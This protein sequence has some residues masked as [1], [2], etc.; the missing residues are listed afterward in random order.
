M[1]DEL[2]A[3]PKTEN[4]KLKARL[5]G[6][7]SAVQVLSEIGAA[8]AGRWIATRLWFI[9]LGLLQVDMKSF[10]FWLPKLKTMNYRK[11]ARNAAL[12][13]AGFGGLTII[14]QLV[15]P[16]GRILPGVEIQGFGVGGRDIVAAREFLEEE[17]SHA[18]LALEA[19]GQVIE[20]SFDKAG[21]RIDAQATA[22]AAANYPLYQRLIPFSSLFIMVKRDVVAQV[23]YDDPRLREFARQVS[24]RA[25]VPAKNAGVKIE[26]G[27]AKLVASEP[28]R[29]FS[30]EGVIESIKQAKLFPQTSIALTEV[31]NPPARTDDKVAGVLAAAQKVVD[32]PF[33]LILDGESFE[34]KKDDLGSWLDFAEEENGGLRLA[35]NRDA[36]QAYLEEVQKKVYTEPGTTVISLVD[37][38]E[39]G[40]TNA[41]PGRGIDMEVALERLAEAIAKAEDRVVELPLADLPPRVVYER[42][43]TSSSAGLVALLNDIAREKGDYGIAVMEIGGR[44]GMANADKQ[45]TAASTFKFFIAYAVFQ[46]VNSGKMSWSDHIVGGRNAAECFDAMIV[47]SDNACPVAFADKIGWQT[48][49]DM[50]RGLGLSSTQFKPGDHLTTANDLALFLHKLESGTL[51]NP[52]DKAR[53]IDA[54]KRQVYRR[55]IPA[56]VGAPVANKPGFLYDLLHDAGI[57]YGPKGAYVLVIMSDKS[58][59]SE[60]ADTARRIHD[61]LQQ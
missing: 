16:S 3:R 61:F 60:L 49:H 11:A 6:S 13:V 5:A 33:T 46:W 14:L 47:K 27:K 37:G 40:R 18:K 55:G 41:A 23:H 58:S 26:G 30:P 12:G 56:G 25:F 54:M 42:K 15:Y 43:L 32:S 10:R 21:L 22:S 28:S 4:R 8:T 48:I 45:Y 1:T 44:S 39:S 52:Q 7:E 50:M 2:L 59:W 34:V 51:L 19:G 53:L 20:S 17:Y 35:L 31:N 38:V 9:L 24:D 29:E 57:V 36:A